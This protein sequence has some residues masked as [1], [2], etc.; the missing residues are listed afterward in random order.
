MHRVPIATRISINSTIIVY[1][2]LDVI[3]VEQINISI[4]LFTYPE[5]RKKVETEGKLLRNATKITLN[6]ITIFLFLFLRTDY[7]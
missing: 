1:L 4:Q 7:P 6:M 2:S 5:H 3:L